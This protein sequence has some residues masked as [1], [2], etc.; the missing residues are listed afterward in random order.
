M[1]FLI[2]HFIDTELLLSKLMKA[3]MAP[4]LQINSL[5]E[6]FHPAIRSISL[7]ETPL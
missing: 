7:R 5:D 2:C 3:R 1:Q 6:R 4:L